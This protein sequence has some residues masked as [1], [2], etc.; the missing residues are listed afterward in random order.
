MKIVGIT[1]GIGSGK[2]IVCA[3]FRQL[4]IPVY[5][6]DTEAKLLYDKYP[7]LRKQVMEQISSEVFDSSGKL[8]RKKLGEIVFHDPSKLSLLNKFVHPLVRKDFLNWVNAQH[9]VPYVLKE[10]AILFESGAHE[11][12][13]KVIAVVAPA[14][15]RLQRVRERD[16]KSKADVEAIMDRQSPDEEKVK[17]SDFVITNDE[18]EL[19][20]PQVLSI[21]ERL[22]K[23]SDVN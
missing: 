19:V 4:G 5:D 18:K 8:D 11:D 13:D 12:C 22:Q 17:R 15:L 6:A 23:E 20:V 21:H 2:S 10:A 3:L 9:G 7:E 1:G 16:R 14:E